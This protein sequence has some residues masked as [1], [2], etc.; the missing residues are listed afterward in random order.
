MYLKL[1]SLL[2][3]TAI[4]LAQFLSSPSLV[5]ADPVTF[6]CPDAAHQQ[7]WDCEAQGRQ[8]PSGCVPSGQDG[9]QDES[10]PGEDPGTP[11]C[12][13]CDNH[14]WRQRGS[15]TGNSCDGV[16]DPIPQCDA[17]TN[18]S[19]NWEGCVSSTVQKDDD[20][21]IDYCGNGSCSYVEYTD[22][23]CPLDCGD[24][25][26]TSGGSCTPLPIGKVTTTIPQG[27]TRNT[28]QL[29]ANS[30]SYIKDGIYQSVSSTYDNLWKMLRGSKESNTN[31]DDK[32]NPPASKVTVA[33]R[34]IDAPAGS[35]LLTQQKLDVPINSFGETFARADEISKIFKSPKNASSLPTSSEN[36]TDAP[37]ED[38]QPQGKVI[39]PLNTSF[40]DSILQA[41]RDLKDRLISWITGRQNQQVEVE[42]TSCTPFD[43]ENVDRVQKIAG[44]G[45]GPGANNSLDKYQNNSHNQTVTIRTGQNARTE[46]L[47]LATLGTANI[48]KGL[49]AL[50]SQVQPPGYDKFTFASLSSTTSSTAPLAPSGSIGS[51][52]QQAASAAGVPLPMLYAIAHRESGTRFLTWTDST[53]SKY[54]ADKWWQNATPAELIEG[55]A[56]NTCLN[57]TCYNVR[58]FMQF[59]NTTFDAVV[60]RFNLSSRLGHDP[61]RENASDSIYA[62]AFHLRELGERAWQLTG[63]PYSAASWSRDV[64]MY[65]ARGYCG[66]SG[67][68]TNTNIDSD[69]ACG[70]GPGRQSYPVEAWSTYQSYSG[71]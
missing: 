70:G 29:E 28:F 40:I 68:M 67:N 48:Y 64:V 14:K 39:I 46:T 21:D 37:V 26:T 13:V 59:L 61:A 17:E 35:D 42:L 4:L 53:F 7:T 66:G 38:I 15:N 5:F 11:Q 47:N 18:T 56:T 65:V 2:F 43:K 63:D 16:Q 31:P 50:I 24:I 30:L 52:F 49:E 6:D 71:N 23:S 34:I 25:V 51:T 41:G 22:Q 55:L 19:N 44:F 1:S 27:N 60:T 8:N 3:T 9:C 32:F 58:G 20:C 12:W 54:S 45:I 62:S 36:V 57:G 33:G 69:P 10:D